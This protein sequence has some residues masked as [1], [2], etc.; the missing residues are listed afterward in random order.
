MPSADDLRLSI[1]RLLLRPV[2]RWAMKK[3]LSIKEFHSMTKRAF[4][5]LAEEE[6][7]AASGDVSIS[8]I[9]A[10]TGVH[11]REVARLLRLPRAHED[12]KTSV[13]SRVMQQWRSDR[14]FCGASGKPKTLSFEGED[15]EFHKLVSSVSKNMNAYPMLFELVRRGAVEKTPRGL[16][17][18]ASIESVSEDVES[19][20]KLLS[21]D[22]ESLI[23]AG[24]ENLCSKPS[25]YN[26]HFRTE[27]DNIQPGKIDEIR[28][29]LIA[30]GKN[31]HRRARQYLAAFDEDVIPSSAPAL[32][33]D[34][35]QSDEKTP[36]GSK[37][38]M[39]SFSLTSAK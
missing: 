10:A 39:S 23:T 20:F 16:K 13:L 9:T 3:G 1:L 37:V 12:S 28:R 27:Y 17:L 29:W 5:D 35:T 14:R 33:V 8:R 24:E 31:L 25:V 38:V 15:S 18:T 7:R 21:D 4:L 11:R 19:G 6:I 34:D 2:V 26:M 32:S 22:I 36:K 30:E